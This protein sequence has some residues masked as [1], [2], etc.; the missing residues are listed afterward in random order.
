M[1]YWLRR[2]SPTFQ[3]CIPVN[4]IMYPFSMSFSHMTNPRWALP[5]LWATNHFAKATHPLT[6]RETRASLD[7]DGLM[8]SFCKY[9]ASAGS[10]WR[11]SWEMRQI[12]CSFCDVF[13]QPS[14]SCIRALPCSV[15][16]KIF[17]VHVLW[18]HGSGLQ[19]GEPGFWR[20]ATS[21]VCL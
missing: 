4:D 2:F 6:K 5:F 3:D 16:L 18:D 12:I 13:T 15:A 21:E 19:H 20:C 9:Q 14:Q 7:R 1:R 17:G 11:L 8:E 10:H